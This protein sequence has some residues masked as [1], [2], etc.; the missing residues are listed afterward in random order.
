MNNRQ[1]NLLIAALVVA[2][3]MVLVPPFQ[4]RLL[5]GFVHDGGYG[6]IFSPPQMG[7]IRGTVDMTLLFIQW[8]GVALVAAI[9]YLFMRDR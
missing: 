9:G 7:A 3:L 5:N 2:L 4:I 1:R 6:W 8:A